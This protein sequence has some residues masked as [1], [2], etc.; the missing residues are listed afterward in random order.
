MPDRRAEIDAGVHGAVAQDRMLAH[1]EARGDVR[2][3]HRRAQEGA[4]H[5]LA[6]GVVELLGAAVRA[7]ADH[8]DGALAEMSSPASRRPGSVTLPSLVTSCSSSTVK[9]WP[10]FSSR[11]KSTS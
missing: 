6:L 1:A 3:I 11:W 5:A 10:S 7:E 4:H 8:R 9:F 2:G